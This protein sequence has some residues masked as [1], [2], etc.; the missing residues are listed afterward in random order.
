MEKVTTIKDIA[1]IAGVHHSTVSRVIN[2]SDMISD[3]TKQKVLK[4]MKENDFQINQH[5]RSLSTSKTNTIL[6]VIF[7]LTN[8]FYAESTRG[9]ISRLNDSGY[10]VVI[11][12]N[13]YNKSYEKIMKMI[14]NKQCDGVIFV[15]LDCL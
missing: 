15:G 12:E 10:D 6:I 5:A 14:N 7:D 13:K 4:V 3:S 8:P 9:I 1:R 11:K 2:N